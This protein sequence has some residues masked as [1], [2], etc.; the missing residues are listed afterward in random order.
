MNAIPPIRLT[1]DEFLR[2]S[3][4]QESGRYELEQGRIVKM[5]SENI[6]HTTTKRRVVD[7]LSTAIERAG[8][9]YY[10][11]P[12]GPTVRIDDD[13]AYE[14]DALI[15]PLPMPSLDALEI[16]DPIAVFE[17]LSPSPTSVKRDLTTKLH[18]YARVPS[19][20]HYVVIDPAERTVFRFRRHA[21]ELVATE[22]L[23]EGVLRLDPPGLDVPVADMLTPVES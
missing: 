14:P 19:I 2:W 1:V 13:R 21:D 15:A 10:A 17:V 16:P 12:D 23:T 4:E 11:L 22:E 18:G 8:V 20:Q 3:L 9:P 7:A 6:R 5:Q